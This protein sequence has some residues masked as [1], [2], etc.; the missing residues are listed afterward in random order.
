MIVIIIINRKM[1]Y[2]H[3]ISYNIC[4]INI[5]NN[6]KCNNKCNYKKNSYGALL[7]KKKTFVKLL[8]NIVAIIVNI[9]S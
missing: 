6:N 7:G 8:Q 2:Y 9:K 5:H 1:Y 3:N 4:N